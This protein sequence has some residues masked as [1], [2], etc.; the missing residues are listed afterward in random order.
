MNIRTDD[1]QG[2]EIRDVL[3]AHLNLMQSITPQ[4]HVH[5]L[6]LDALRA[7][8]VTLWSAWD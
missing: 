3:Q 2:V 6:D 8:D 1:L 5:A 7:T 4:G